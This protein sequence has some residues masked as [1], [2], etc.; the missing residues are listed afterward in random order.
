MTRSWSRGPG[1][2]GSVSPTIPGSP[3]SATASALA[4]TAAR[5]RDGSPNWCCTCSP[6]HTS[7]LSRTIA[8]AAI[9][10]RLHRVTVRSVPS[11]VSGAVAAGTSSRM[12]TRSHSDGRPS[13]GRPTYAGAP[14][15][16]P[17]Q[18]L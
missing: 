2:G 1:P 6:S 3:A 10:S 7:P 16:D 14:S 4:S 13:N 5:S 9:G 18:A 17:W 12:A 8:G 11:I 15:A